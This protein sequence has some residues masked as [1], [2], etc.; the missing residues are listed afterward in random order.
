MS[1]VIAGIDEAGYGPLLGPMCVGMSV[2]RIEPWREGDPAPDLWKL[3]APQV[4]RKPG[5]SGA[6][7]IDDSKKLKLSN[8]SA[9]LHP[10]T[11]LERA[12]LA[13]LRCRE[14]DPAAPAD[15]A[16]L[17]EALGATLAPFDCYCGEPLTLP[18][19]W[20]LV[21][22]G[23]T[24][25]LFRAALQRAEVSLLSLRCDTIGEDRFNETVD[26][27]GTKASVTLRAVAGHL[28]A[29]LALPLRDD[30]SVRLVCDRLGGRTDYAGVLERM[31]RELDPHAAV[32]TTEET[33]RR[34]RYEVT[35]NS[36][37]V[38]IVFQTEG[39][40]AHLPVALASMVA[41]YV[42]ELAMSR[43]N[44]HWSA[45]FAAARSGAGSV[46]ELKPTAGYRNDATRWLLD[47]API[48][49]PEDRRKLIRRA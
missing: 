49:T 13:G 34:S 30:D 23:I 21:Q 19:A 33:D 39:D 4:A 7:A 27:T 18:V 35:I 26:R 24:S 5:K 16:T 36:R 9:T 28:G 3:L 41:K 6:L 8:D 45:R 22:V 46:T 43:F 31:A 12:V 48:L 20:S 17:H 47:A 29:L 32:E 25:N 2:F 40:A 14:T 44:R 1:L 10:L 38:G 37:R 11:H 42:R 15:D